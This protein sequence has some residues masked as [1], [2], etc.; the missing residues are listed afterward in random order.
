MSRAVRRVPVGYEHPHEYDPHW[1]YNNF[2]NKNTEIP[3]DHRYIALLDGSDYQKDCENVQEEI[4]EIKN[5]KGFSWKFYY[6]AVFEEYYDFMNVWVDPSPLVPVYNRS[7]FNHDYITVENEEQLMD[8]LLK[9]AE[10]GLNDK[11]FYTPIPENDPDTDGFGYCLYE[12]V[13]EG[14]PV[15][16]VFATEEELVDYLVENGNFWGQKYTRENSEAL[17][18]NGSSLGSFA[19]VDGKSYN[20]STQAAELDEALNNN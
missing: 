18:G 15:T 17:V 20:S 14:T 19:V 3:P 6:K 12:E 2:D 13:S 10:Q 8:A 7:T 1:Q 16:P 4:N 5:K 9:D 11:S